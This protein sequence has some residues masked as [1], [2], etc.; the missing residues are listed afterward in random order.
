MFLVFSLSQLKWL[1]NKNPQASHLP[2]FSRVNRFHGPNVGTK[3][4]CRFWGRITKLWTS[5]RWMPFSSWTALPNGKPPRYQTVRG[6]FCV[7]NFSAWWFQVGWNPIFFVGIYISIGE[8]K[9]Y[10]YIYTH[11]FVCG[12][13]GRNQTTS[14]QKQKVCLEIRDLGY[15]NWSTQWGH[16]YGESALVH[17]GEPPNARDQIGWWVACWDASQVIKP[18]LSQILKRWRNIWETNWHGKK[19]AIS[20]APGSFV[21]TGSRFVVEINLFLKNAQTMPKNTYIYIFMYIYIYIYFYLFIYIYITH[22]KKRQGVQNFGKKQK[23]QE[24]TA[25]Q[26]EAQ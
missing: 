17:Q 7:H 19:K 21:R 15:L 24:R 3:I 12:Q 5:N 4:L 22:T 14:Q 13:E 26:K 20:L 1:P 6:G 10:I 25:N 16:F 18:W 8:K 2:P 23:Q 11:S 9:I